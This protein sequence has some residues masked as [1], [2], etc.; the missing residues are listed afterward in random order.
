MRCRPLRP[1][2]PIRHGYGMDFLMPGMLYMVWLA[3]HCKDDTIRK[4]A[5]QL[6]GTYVVLIV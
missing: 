6:R 3:W 5:S 1:T 4:V 2:V